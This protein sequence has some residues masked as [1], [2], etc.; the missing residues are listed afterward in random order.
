M[1][2]KYDYSYERTANYCYPDSTVLINKL[3]IHDETELFN[4]ER[5]YVTVRT[6]ILEITPIKGNFA[7]A[8]LKEIHKHLFQDIYN[9]AGQPRTCNIAKQDLFCLAQYIDGYAEDVF[10]KFKKENYFLNKTYDE[11]IT[12]LVELFADINALHPFRERKW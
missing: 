8:H 3:D 1:S 4:A 11:K 2:N 10:S 12:A 6:L 5:E 9:W 7:F